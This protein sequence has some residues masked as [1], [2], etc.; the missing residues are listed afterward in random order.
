VFFVFASLLRIGAMF[1]RGRIL[2]RDTFTIVVW[3]ALPLVILLPLGIAFYQVL[4]GDAMSVWVPLIIG[5]ITVW[6]I[7]RM[8]RATSVVFDVSSTIVYL[9]GFGFVLL[10]LGSL[11][12]I[13]VGRY[14]AAAFVQYY[15]GVVSA[16]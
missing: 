10:T 3:S 8:L 5:I 14:D 15:L 6:F 11:T 4:S 12:W 7:V 9:V 1:V 16:G 2:M 13:Y